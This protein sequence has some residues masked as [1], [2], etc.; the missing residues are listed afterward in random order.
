[1]L[2]FVA[3]VLLVVVACDPGTS[4][5]TTT[6]SSTTTTIIDDTC[7]RVASDTVA[8]LDSLISRLD[9][10]RLAEFR[11]RADW[12]DD[13]RDLERAGRD[14]DIRVAALACDPAL[15]QRRALDEAN[16]LPD[17]PLSEGLIDVLLTPQTTTTSSIPVTTEVVDTTT[18]S[19]TADTSAPT[20]TAGG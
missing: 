18:V 14:L 13:L 5:T 12:P 4:G 1:M 8:F 17:G 16:L 15:I 10:T 3:F 9:D 6:T 11:H 7:D 2:R 20:T 19:T